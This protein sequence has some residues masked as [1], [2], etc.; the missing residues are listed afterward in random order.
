MYGTDNF[1]KLKKSPLAIALERYLKGEDTVPTTEQ[2][3]ENIRLEKRKI[4]E[5]MGID[6]EKELT[7]ILEKHQDLY[8]QILREL[9]SKKRKEVEDSPNPYM[10]MTRLAKEG[11]WPDFIMNRV[12]D[13]L[14]SQPE[15]QEPKEP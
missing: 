15:K 1:K 9:P 11:L 3:Y 8:K 5:K 4:M 2:I 12:K 10:S 13:I 6:I 7:K 14:E